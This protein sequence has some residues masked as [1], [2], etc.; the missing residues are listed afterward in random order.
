MSIIKFRAFS[1]PPVNMALVYRFAG[2][3]KKDIQTQR[4]VD[5]CVDI[6][7]PELEYKVCFGEFALS[8]EGDWLNLGFTRTKSKVLKNH[9]SGCNRVLVFA[10]T[11]GLEAD[12]IITKYSKLSPSKAVVLQAIGAERAESLCDVFENE[13]KAEHTYIARRFSPGYGDFALETQKDIFTHLNC[14]RL[15]GIT[16]NSNMLITPTKS[17]TAVIGIKK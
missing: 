8:F 11:I 5:E 2:I 9:L 3:G 13:I 10:A 6:M 16:L 17:V 1:A 4:L 12:R 7:L 14:C 15:L